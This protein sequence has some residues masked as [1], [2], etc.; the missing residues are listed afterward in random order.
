MWSFNIVLTLLAVG[1]I[2][3]FIAGLLGIGGGTVIVP[4]VL[5]TLQL[6]G[7][8]NHPYAQHLAIGTSFAVMVFTTLSSVIAQNRKKTVDWPTVFRMTPG[9]II[10]V[11]VGSASA[12]FIPTRGLQI[13]FV[14]FLIIIA[15]KTLTDAKPQPS[16][17]LPHTLGLNGVGIFFGIASSWVG[18]GGGSLSVPF[19]MYCNIPTH[20]AVGTSSGLAWPIAVAG[21]IGYALSGSEIPSLPTGSFGF[22]YLPAVA[23]LSVATVLF[24]PLGVKVAHKLPPS[25]LKL[26]FGILLLLIAIKMLWKMI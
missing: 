21:T 11:L 12:K 15:I 20:R 4:I 5:W 1:S 2:S 8:G 10:G 25:Q 16:R 13:F 7:L 24:A 19:L 6:Q 22:L 14:V 17:Q 23:I 9:M 3:G 26:A 18:I